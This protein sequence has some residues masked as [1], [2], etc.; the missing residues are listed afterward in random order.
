MMNQ[1][2]AT[3]PTF[4]RPPPITTVHPI[5]PH[6]Q[7]PDSI[8]IFHPNREVTP[9]PS[10][11]PRNE[12]SQPLSII[13]W[14]RRTQR[15]ANDAPPRLDVSD[16]DMSSYYDFSSDTLDPPPPPQPRLK[17]FAVVNR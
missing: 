11:D 5:Y 12:P 10:L 14:Q 7:R 8:R 13:E 15:E 2:H 1:E 9:T 17:R 3:A 16:V 4:R 6:L